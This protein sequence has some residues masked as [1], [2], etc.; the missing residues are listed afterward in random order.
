MRSE[1]RTITIPG[2]PELRLRGPGDAPCVLLLGGSSRDDRPGVWSPSTE[3][4]AARL[5]T[6]RADLLVAEVRYRHG[7][8]R[9]MDASVEDGRLVRG[10]LRSM[11]S[12]VRAAVGFSLGGAI[13]V[14][15]ADDPAV[16][17]VVALA[18][19]LPPTVDLG[20]LAGRRLRIAHGTLDGRGPLLP[21]IDPGVSESAARRA[22]GLG[23]DVERTVIRG[24]VHG[25]AVRA[26]W[27]GLVPLPRAGAWTRIVRDEVRRVT[28]VDASPQASAALAG[29]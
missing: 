17:A 19:W 2:G 5:A 25:I 9:R 13:A 8:W 29:G 26:P 4:L 7:S 27:G 24:A 10:A 28:G 21:G 18:P 22:R 15:L 14:A 6:R 11:G 3:W 1:T 16:Q 20:R 23:V 12:P